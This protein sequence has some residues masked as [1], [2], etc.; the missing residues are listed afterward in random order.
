MNALATRI[1]ALTTDKVDFL[2]DEAEAVAD[3]IVTAALSLDDAAD[4]FTALAGADTDQEDVAN[5]LVDLADLF[6]DLNLGPAQTDKLNSVVNGL[7]K[8]GTD[9]QKAAAKTLFSA[10]LAYGVQ[11]KGANE[12]FDTLLETEPPVDPT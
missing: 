3:G 8:T 10:T 6:D 7:L 12:Y 4:A 11:A 5:A 2:S 1:R 9:E